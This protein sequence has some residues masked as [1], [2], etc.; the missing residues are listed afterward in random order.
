MRGKILFIEQ[1]N[2]IDWGEMYSIE[3][4][5]EAFGVFYRTYKRVFEQCFPIKHVKLKP[6]RKNNSKHV[7]SGLKKSICECKRLNRLAFKWPHTYRD[8]YC[9]YKS[10]LKVLLKEAEAKY[11]TD[12][13]NSY[14]GNCKNTWSLIGKIL[15]KSK[16]KN[17]P[18]III[19][20][21]KATPE[22]INNYFKD[23][24]SKI[25]QDIPS[26]EGDDVHLRFLGDEVNFSMLLLPTSEEEIRAL[27]KTIK[28]NSSGC[29]E[30]PPNIFKYSLDAI[31]KPLT[32]V[33]NL[34]LKEGK[35]PSPLKEA[36]VI[37]IHKS[38]DQKDIKNKRQVSVLNSISMLF[39]KVLHKRFCNYFETNGLI[40]HKQHGFRKGFSTES[41]IANVLGSVYKNINNKK[42][43]AAIF[44]DYSKAFDCVEHRILLSKLKHLGVRGNAYKLIE[45][46]LSNRK[47]RVFYN[48]QYSEPICIKYGVPQGSVMG[49]LLFS[50]YLND[51]LN[52][53]N[54]L[55]LSLFADDKAGVISDNCT[56]SLIRKLNN[57]L[58]LLYKWV[59]ANKL[60]LNMDKTVFMIFSHF[61]SCN[62]NPPVLIGTHYIN[63]VYQS[64]YLGLRPL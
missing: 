9:R 30:I 16:N 26:C 5:E 57:E 59:L 39:E 63:Q 15:N 51:V 34:S 12:Q 17:T 47:Q 20:N 43:T 40:S 64:K 41:A 48:G 31:I 28:S 53:C 61:P 19:D 13:F 4:C 36:K 2:Q 8:R 55:D 44:F 33:I 21:E 52:V 45:S 62:L 42:V 56:A 29:D 18:E 60:S 50:I 14:Q 27:C 49:P 23:S 24:I 3:D 38:G 1:L 58:S 32:H 10:K 35:F 22:S 25:K 54:N 7:T 11:Y 46:Y 6:I 37:P